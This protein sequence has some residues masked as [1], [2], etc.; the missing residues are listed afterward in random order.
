MD[1]TL[2]QLMTK[3]QITIE[4]QPDL[5][6]INKIL[7]VIGCEAVQFPHTAILVL[8]DL[9]SGLHACAPWKENTIEEAKAI[10]YKIAH[11]SFIDRES[12]T[13]QMLLKNSWI[14]E[15]TAVKLSFTERALI[16]F[17]DFIE[18]MNCGFKKCKFLF[19][20]LN[21]KKQVGLMT[22]VV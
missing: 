14:R 5:L 15:E 11:N 12:S 16:Q 21:K 9:S 19:I 17:A 10:F 20:L 2:L 1:Q 3:G 8:K 22:R 7:N 6:K 13:V 18:E 4:Q